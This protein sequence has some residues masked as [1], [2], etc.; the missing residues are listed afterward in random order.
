MQ[1]RIDI[2]FSLSIHETFAKINYLPGHNEN[3]NK[4]QR[5]NIIDIQD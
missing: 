2:L 1:Y 5:I 3:L 4:S